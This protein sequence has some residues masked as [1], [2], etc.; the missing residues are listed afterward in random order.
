ML[1]NLDI[2]VGKFFWKSPTNQFIV[3]MTQGLVAWASLTLFQWVWSQGESWAYRITFGAVFFVLAI[4][5]SIWMDK[6]LYRKEK[7]G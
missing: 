7:N 3:A 5:V 1:K 6:Y 2:K 4:P